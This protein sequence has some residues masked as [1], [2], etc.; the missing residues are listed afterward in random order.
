MLICYIVIVRVVEPEL[1]ELSA[2]KGKAK[3]LVEVSLRHHI[4][5]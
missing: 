4:S 5:G 1:T 2:R 3:K